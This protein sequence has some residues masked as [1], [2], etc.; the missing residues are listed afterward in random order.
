MTETQTL[1]F[2]RAQTGTRLRIYQ[3]L[4]AISIV[5]NLIV[6]LWCIIA[7]VSF[8]QQV[9]QIDPHPQAWPRIWGATFAGL[10]FVYIPGVRNPLF[11][12][13][14]NWFSIAIKFSMSAIFV[15]AGSLFYLLATWE[16]V[17]VIIL[18]VAY[19]R[20]TLADIRGRP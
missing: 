10:Q 15:V 16:F 7:P 4:F 13:W 14:P 3:T 2:T 11:Y 9:L 18:I 1:S 6:A 17:W 12:R 8:A 20:L 19:Y 5:S